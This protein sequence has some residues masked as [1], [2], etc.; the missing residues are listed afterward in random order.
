MLTF[1]IWIENGGVVRIEQVQADS[2][3]TA[4]RMAKE[5]CEEWEH[6]RAVVE[7]DST[8]AK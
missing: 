3:V 4:Y 1:E 5:L 8:P 6:V 7:L 2:E